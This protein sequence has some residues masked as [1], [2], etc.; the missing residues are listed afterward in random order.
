MIHRN[1]LAAASGGV[2]TSIPPH[3]FGRGSHIPLLAVAK[4]SIVI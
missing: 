4:M 2:M 3:A 1:V